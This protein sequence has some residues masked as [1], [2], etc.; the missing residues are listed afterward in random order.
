MMQ[1]AEIAEASCP[2]N[3]TTRPI[4]PCPPSGLLVRTLYAGLCHSDVHLI[5][6]ELEVGGG[7]VA[8]LRD[9][10]GE[11]PSKKTC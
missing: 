9:V 10:L 5:D 2:L 11:L 3:I 7:K 8:R 4:P 6:D 1:C